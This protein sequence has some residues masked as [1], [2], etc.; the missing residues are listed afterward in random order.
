MKR[1]LVTGITGQ[2]GSFLA[3]HLI[4]LGY[5]VWGLVRRS[6]DTRSCDRI[7]ELTDGK[8]KLRY[9]D[10]CDSASLH[11]IV[12]E[13]KP[14]EIYNLAAQSHVRISSD[15]PEYTS[16]VNGTG[17]ISLLEAVRN[18][19]PEARFYQ[20]S[21]SELFGSSPPPQ[22]EETV[23]HPRSP[24]GVA[25]LHGYWSVINMRESYGMFAS[26]GILFNHESE[27]RGENFV[28]RKITRA[29]ARIKLGKQSSLELGNMDALRD[30]GH[31]KDY[32]AGMHLILQH[33]RPDDFVLATGIARSVREFVE[34]AFAHVGIDIESNG[35]FTIDEVYHR[36]DT[37]D[38]IITINEAFYRPAEVDYLCGD[39]SKAKELLGWSP[40]VTFEQLVEKMVVSDLNLEG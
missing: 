35:K 21:T 36:V 17:V 14:H 1:A 12:G 5:E 39:A 34:T 6:S 40:Q 3:E 24:Y 32:V 23:M 37:G 19:A 9:G 7:R 16:T 28:T 33:D 8:V 29:V 38:P 31:A 10:M 18:L 22:N 25:K 2:D 4:G 13:C 15:I 26:N 20:A 30:W 27:R 11:R